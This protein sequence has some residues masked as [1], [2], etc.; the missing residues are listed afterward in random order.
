MAT[1]MEMGHAAILLSFPAEKLSRR[2]PKAS[3]VALSRPMAERS[4]EPQ[5]II[6]LPFTFLTELL[7][8]PF[9]VSATQLW[10]YSG[11]KTEKRCFATT[12]A[13]FQAKF[14]ELISLPEKSQWFS[15]YG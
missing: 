10:Q 4:L 11:R 8:G 2:L 14:T 6:L 15:S 7:R 5:R 1:G 9:L 12:L 3:A 13:S